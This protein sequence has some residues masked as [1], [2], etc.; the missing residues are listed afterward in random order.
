MGAQAVFWT[1]KY[2]KEVR[3]KILRK[4]ADEHW[5]AESNRDFQA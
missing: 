3:P 4:R 2:L 5:L 1:G